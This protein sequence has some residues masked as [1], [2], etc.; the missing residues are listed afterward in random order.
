MIQNASLKCFF[1]LSYL[2][3]P[4]TEIQHSSIY[5]ISSSSPEYLTAYEM[6]KYHRYKTYTQPFLEVVL[7]VFVEQATKC[8]LKH[9]CFSL[10][11]AILPR[12]TQ[13]Q[14]PHILC[15]VR[16][17][18]SRAIRQAASELVNTSPSGQERVQRRE[19]REERE[20]REERR[21]NS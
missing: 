4:T 18:A 15:V 17:W 8:K 11:K 7:N 16:K 10:F 6:N 2:K 12:E 14:L 9:L 13:C 3:L 20:E 5:D 1:Q 21:T 19:A